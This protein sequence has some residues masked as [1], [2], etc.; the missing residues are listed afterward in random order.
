MGATHYLIKPLK[1]V[2]TKNNLHVLAYNLKRMKSI[3]GAIGLVKAMRQWLLYL[4][5]K[6]ANSQKN[7]N[8]NVTTCHYML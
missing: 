2:S 1:N 7:T 3:K 4:V 8:I 6:L 5:K